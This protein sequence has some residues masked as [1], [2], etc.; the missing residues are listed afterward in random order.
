MH[1][2]VHYSAVFN[3]IKYLIFSSVC[4]LRLMQIMFPYISLTNK[5]KLFILF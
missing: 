2:I 3:Y 5:E 1:L 4:Y